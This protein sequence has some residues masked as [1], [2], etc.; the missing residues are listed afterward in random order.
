MG[1]GEALMKLF[2]LVVNTIFA[3]GGLILIVIGVVKKL[4][5]KN[6]SEAIPDDYSIEVAPIL[7]IVVG[8]IIFVIAFFGCWGAIR[9]S[10]FLLTTYGVILLV[11]FLLQIAVGIFAVTHIKDEENFKIQVKKQVIRVF[12]EAKRNKK[13][14]LTDLIQKDFHCCGP[15][16]SS[17][18]GNDIPDSCFDSHKHQYKDGCKIKVYE[19][20]HKTMFIIGITVIAFSVLEVIGCIFSLCLASRIKK[21]ER[22]FSY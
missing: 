19:F 5:V 15:D 21:R 2:M 17:F 18:W 20:L 7:T 4:N 8:V 10:P 13:Y 3:L 6:L 16:G 12:N 22:R 14:E 11:I 9:D 1:C